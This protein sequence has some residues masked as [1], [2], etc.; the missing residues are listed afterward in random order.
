MAQDSWPSPAH[1]DRA[2]TDAE[3]EQMAARDSDDGIYGIP[4]DPAVVTAAAGLNINVR[5]GVTAT[6]RG[7]AWTSGATTVTL[8]I[9]ANGSGQTRLDRVVL[10]LDRATW[11]VR[12]VV[13]QGTPGSGAP[14]LTRASGP[15]GVWE[16]HL[17]TATVAPGA[18]TPTVARGEVYVG[19]RIRPAHSTRL[20]PTPELGEM[21]WTTDTRELRVWDGSAW[22]T[23][24]SDSGPIVVNGWPNQGWTVQTDSVLHVRNGVAYL[25]LG[26]FVRMGATLPGSTV[27]RLPVLIPAEYRHPD[28]DQYLTCYV[29]GGDVGRITIRSAGSEDA[30]QVW[31][32][33]KP[34]IALGR[35]VLTSGTSWVVG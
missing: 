12:A 17:A 5:A 27:S 4:T 7:H 30:G 10:R 13:K 1:N 20:N 19:S 6:V 25:R 35:T 29:A 3:Y 22:T 21:V 9:A 15:G 23:T 11:T 2:V 16:V 28:R 8:P 32:T 26:S 33:Q 14:S 34:D 31:L 18:L 24:H